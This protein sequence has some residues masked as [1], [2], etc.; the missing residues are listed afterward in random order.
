MSHHLPSRRFVTLQLALAFPSFARLFAADSRTQTVPAAMAHAAKV[1]LDS[2]WG[3]QR[4][5]A[6]FEAADAEQFNWF[7]TPVPRKGLPLREM[8]SGQRQLALALLSAGLSQ[9]GFAKSLT[10]MSLEEILASVEGGGNDPLRRDPDGYFFSIFGEPG[11]SGAW[12]YR[13]EGHHLSLHFAIKNGEL[14]SAAPTFFGVNPATVLHGR[15]KGLRT[16]G[17]EEDLARALVRGLNAE[18]RAAA[19][20]ATRAPGDI[21]TEHSR[22][23]ALSGQPNGVAI[24]ALSGT[25]ANALQALLGEY[26]DNMVAE[27]AAFRRAQISKAGK[28]V[29]FA[30]AG[31]IEPGEG[32]YY[33]I[34]SSEFLVEFDDTQD[35]ANHIHSVWRD[36]RGDFGRDLLAEHYGAGHGRISKGSAEPWR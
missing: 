10:V 28:D 30:W 29:W 35:G 17:N 2:L 15:R 34:Q 23:A 4:A 12:G 31:G 25:Q 1:F 13:V 20:V 24:G 7:Y 9:N 19:I 27:I 8:T 11:A 36:F 26:C 21:L 18:Q 16:L 5:K 14:V 22:Q 3:E 33:R 6:F 32:H